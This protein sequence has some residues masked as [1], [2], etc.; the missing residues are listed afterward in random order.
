MSPAEV[1]HQ[2]KSTAAVFQPVPFHYLETAKVLFA[3]AKACFGPDLV[4]VQGISIRAMVASHL[5]AC[6]LDLAP[7]AMTQSGALLANAQHMSSSH[8]MLHQW[9]CAQMVCFVWSAGQRAS[10]RH[11][12]GEDVQDIRR[13]PSPAGTN[14]CEAEQSIGDGVQ[15]CAPILPG[16]PWSIPGFG[17][18]VCFCSS[19]CHAPLA[20]LR[21][22]A[23]SLHSTSSISSA[24]SIL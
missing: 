8:M 14:D 21:W 17:W 22:R 16:V 9:G 10:R 18:G 5:L 11:L 2:E 3:E 20:T 7:C 24:G 12:Q 15:C 13:P 23:S 6:Q 1:L 19:T 4:K